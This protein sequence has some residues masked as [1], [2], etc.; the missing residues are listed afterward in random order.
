MAELQLI[1]VPDQVKLVGVLVQF[2]FKVTEDPG[3]MALAPALEVGL[4][5]GAPAGGGVLPAPQVMLRLP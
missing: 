3:A 1:P 4:Q 2:A 5:D